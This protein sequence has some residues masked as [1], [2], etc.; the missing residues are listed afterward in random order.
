ML[1]PICVFL[2]SP[3]G[4][5][6]AG[7]LLEGLREGQDPLADGALVCANNEIF[8]TFAKVLREV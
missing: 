1:Y 7:A 6:E 2:D 8:G 5:G 3:P 4:S